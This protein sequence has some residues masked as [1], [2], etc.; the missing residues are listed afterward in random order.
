MSQAAS[1]Q[2]LN[3][4]LLRI[5]EEIR[6]VRDDLETLHRQEATA[7]ALPTVDKA[8][9]EHWADDFFATLGIEGRPLPAEDLQQMMRT[10]GLAA[11]E[12]SRSLI[13]ARDE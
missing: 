11:D 5:E 4:R 1:L 3:D 13:A 6:T 2:Q 12:L 7:C 10:S 9:L 8:S